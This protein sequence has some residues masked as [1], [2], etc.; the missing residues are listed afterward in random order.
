MLTNSLPHQSADSQKPTT[1]EIACELAGM[2]HPEYVTLP[3]QAE[4]A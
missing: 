4:V 1:T 3:H 2:M